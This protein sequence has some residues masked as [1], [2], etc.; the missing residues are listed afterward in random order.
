MGKWGGIE[1]LA[2]AGSGEGEMGRGNLEGKGGNGKTEMLGGG[3]EG[4]IS[5]MDMMKCLGGHINQSTL[6]TRA[7]PGTPASPNKTVIYLRPC[8]TFILPYQ[9]AMTDIY[10]SYI[11]LLLSPSPAIQ[12][13]R[14]HRQA[15]FQV[16]FACR[17]SSQCSMTY[18][19]CDQP[20]PLV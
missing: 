18:L 10:V 7:T 15:R 3:E 19:I 5:Q 20:A 2:R 1:V 13:S 12:A 16:R 8:S 14:A 6:F 4:T 17:P 9:N 11:I